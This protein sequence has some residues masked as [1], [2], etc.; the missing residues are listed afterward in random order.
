MESVADMDKWK[1]D[2]VSVVV[3]GTSIRA[4]SLSEQYSYGTRS[5]AGGPQGTHHQALAKICR[6]D[7]QSL[8]YSCILGYPDEYCIYLLSLSRI[9]RKYSCVNESDQMTNLW[10][11]LATQLRYVS[12]C[13]NRK[14]GS[15][16]LQIIY[17]IKL[18]CFTN[19]A[20]KCIGCM[21][22]KTIISPCRYILSELLYHNVVLL[23]LGFSL[24]KCSQQ[25]S[26]LHL[27]IH[28]YL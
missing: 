19:L 3:E 15:A 10:E 4:R 12:V 25:Y 26:L 23:P 14:H 27:M 21:C 11:T 18:R 9:Q 13:R 8:R 24:P 28:M 17:V 1:W 16:W 5:G 2:W 6:K 22:L 7:I 20:I